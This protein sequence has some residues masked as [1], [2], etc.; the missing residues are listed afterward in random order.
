MTTAFDALKLLSF[1]NIQVERVSVII[2]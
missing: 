2:T 1:V